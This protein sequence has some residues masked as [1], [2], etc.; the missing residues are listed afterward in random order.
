MK[1]NTTPHPALTYIFPKDVPRVLFHIKSYAGAYNHL[2]LV[3]AALGKAKHQKVT[4][5]E[6]AE[7]EGLNADLVLQAV[8]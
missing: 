8:I 7:Y 1:N 4:I 6:F 2:R 5:Q 3:K